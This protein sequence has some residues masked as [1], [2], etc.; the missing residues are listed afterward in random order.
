MAKRR[1]TFHGAYSSKQKANKKCERV[2]DSFV[3]KMRI[4][5]DT[6]YVVMKKGGAK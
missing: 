2:K 1:F 3:R 6:R 5:G 4:R